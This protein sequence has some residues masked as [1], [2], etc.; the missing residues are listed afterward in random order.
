MANDFMFGIYKSY[1]EMGLFTKDDL[2]LF[3]EVGDLSADQE[4]QILG[5]STSAGASESTST[6]NSQA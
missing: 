5:V 4:N 3:V 6:A 2:D 1:Y